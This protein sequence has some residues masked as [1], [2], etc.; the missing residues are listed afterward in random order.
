MTLAGIFP[1]GLFG[2][3]QTALRTYIYLQPAFSRDVRVFRCNMSEIELQVQHDSIHRK[4]V[5]E[6]FETPV[7]SLGPKGD[8]APR[9]A[10]VVS[11]ADSI[12]TVIP[13]P[14][15]AQIVKAR[16]QFISLCWT[17]FLAG[18]NDASTG[19]LLPR[20][21]EVYH[22]SFSI[23][24]QKGALMHT[25]TFRVGGVCRGLIDFRCSMHCKLTI[26]RR[27]TSSL[28]YAPCVRDSYQGLWQMY[29][30]PRN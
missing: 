5:V 18:W 28:V 15:Q 8:H 26:S 7:L 30:Y 22:V 17:L 13:A 21:Q 11:Q 14:S 29:H 27:S 2:N 20:I 23:L 4:P 16:I 10:N 6:D 9:E 19:P 25:S 1:T 3:F 24:S 12:E